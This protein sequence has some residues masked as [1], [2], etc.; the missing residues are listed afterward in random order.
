MTVFEALR[1]LGQSPIN[2]PMRPRKSSSFT[3]SGFA[4]TLLLAAQTQANPKPDEELWVAQSRTTYSIT[5][6]IRLSPTRLR[7]AGVNVPLRVVVDL[8]QYR[9]SDDSLVPARVLEV[10]NRGDFKLRNGNRFGCGKPIRWI[11]VWRFDGGK[12]LGME[13]FEGAMRP[14]SERLHPPTDTLLPYLEQG[15]GFCA[16]YYYARPTRR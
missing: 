5:G 13:T 12:Q 4:A 16:S 1:T 15:P 7:M 8:S 6:D 14:Q 3:R 2:Q 11:V 9:A 10:T